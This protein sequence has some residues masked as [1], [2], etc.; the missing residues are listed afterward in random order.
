MIFEWTVG[1]S[2]HY[3]LPPLIPSLVILLL[4]LL[5]VDINYNFSLSWSL[6]RILY[7]RRK[8]RPPVS[9]RRP[10]GN[11]I[12]LFFLICFRFPRL[13]WEKMIN[14]RCLL[15]RL[16]PPFFRHDGFG[17][18]GGDN[19]RIRLV[20]DYL[21]WF[22]QHFCFFD[23]LTSINMNE[24]VRIGKSDFKVVFRYDWVSIRIFLL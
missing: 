11:F 15:P 24:L 10:P 16:L 5:F 3:G 12:V 21:I 8:I 6:R 7:P 20:I 17:G 22:V 13:I 23:V 9:T 19:R 14:N 1:Q 4:R 2:M 18:G